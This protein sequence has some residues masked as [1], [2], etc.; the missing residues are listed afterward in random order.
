MFAT[1]VRACDSDVAATNITFFH[2]H[3]LTVA[4]R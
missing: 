2:A 1:I 4:R 3:A